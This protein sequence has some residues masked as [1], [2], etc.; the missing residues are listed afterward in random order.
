MQTISMCTACR[1]LPCIC[2]SICTVSHACIVCI[3][4]TTLPHKVLLLLRRSLSLRS[5][6]SGRGKVLVNPSASISF[7]LTHSTSISSCS[8]Y[9]LTHRCRTR[10]CFDLS[11]E[12][13]FTARRLALLLSPNSVCFFA[14]IFKSVHKCSIHISS[15]AALR[16]AFS[17]ASVVSL[18]MMSCQ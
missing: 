8:T 4:I 10:M 12:V 14:V 16:I 11:L 9:S 7:L 6:R 13:G 2:H 5:D 15:F 3:Y 18:P 17:S 1:V